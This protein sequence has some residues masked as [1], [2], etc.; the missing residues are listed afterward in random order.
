MKNKIKGFLVALMYMAIGF[1]VQI[2]VSIIG[3]IIIAV[4]YTVKQGA[5]SLTGAGKEDTTVMIAKQIMGN[6]NYILLASSITTILIFMLIYKLRKKKLSEELRFKKTKASNYGVALLLGVSVYLFN[7]GF[8]SL[9]SKAGLFKGS[10]DALEKNMS[11][12]VESN[13]F[14]TILV[15]GIVAP[16]AEELLF[17]GII[18]KTLSKSMSI[19]TVIIIQGVLFG[20][21][22]M[23]IVQ[24]LYATLLGILF[25]YVTYKTKSLWPAIIM[26]MVNNTVSTIASSILGESLE[27]VFSLIIVLSLGFA[28]T[29]VGTVLIKRNNPK[30]IEHTKVGIEV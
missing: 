11:F 9:L 28:I 15:V 23:N 17:R 10:F 13:I 21:Y 8:I 1:S 18:Y 29:A 30:V 24:G 3:G 20:I 16:F 14:L 27:T 19:P 12:M 4:S 6:M 7:I 25:G 2:I 22:H 26:H 5:D